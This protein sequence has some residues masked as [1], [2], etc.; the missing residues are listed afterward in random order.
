MRQGVWPSHSFQMSGGSLSV[1]GSKKKAG[2]QSDA[3]P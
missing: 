2:T 3:G 1:A